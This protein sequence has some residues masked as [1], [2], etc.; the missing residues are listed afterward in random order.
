MSEKETAF[1]KDLRA[2]LLQVREFRV[3][4]VH[5]DARC[6]RIALKFALLVDDYMSKGKVT[7]EDEKLIDMH[8][9]NLFE[10]TKGELVKKIVRRQGGGANARVD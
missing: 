5:L 1:L 2:A 9:Q 8:A 7:A 3:K 10:E 4:T 6:V